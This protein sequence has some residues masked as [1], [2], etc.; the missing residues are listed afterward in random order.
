M[1]WSK[2]H[3]DRNLDITTKE[4]FEQIY[5]ANV[6]KL[7]DQ[8]YY[9]VKDQE[10]AKSIVQQVFC[11]LWERRNLLTVEGPIEHYLAKA[12]KLAVMDSI[13]IEVNRRKH[14]QQVFLW[15]Q[16]TDFSTENQLHYKE[17]LQKVD[18]L[19]NQ[20][21]PKRQ[22]VY[23][24]SRNEYLNNREIASSLQVSEKTVEKHLTQAL[25]FLKNKLDEYPS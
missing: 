4:G 24:L 9:R 25:K 2:K 18:H 19:V 16:N 8:A 5:R 3:T 13:R 20:L 10:T 1:F 7:I 15:Y 22:Q 21:P 23:R 17:L 14:Q 11:S 6:S 12:V